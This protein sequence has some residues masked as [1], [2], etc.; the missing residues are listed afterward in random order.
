MWPQS[1]NDSGGKISLTFVTVFSLK[2]QLIFS[3]FR[4]Q[5]IIDS[6]LLLACQYVAVSD[7]LSKL[8]DTT[9]GWKRNF[10][11]ETSKSFSY[12][13]VIWSFNTLLV[14]KLMFCPLYTTVE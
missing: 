14:L 9:N 5:V 7:Q 12:L 2:L 11:K 8:G 10:V 4:R 3:L 13:Q 6:R 1:L